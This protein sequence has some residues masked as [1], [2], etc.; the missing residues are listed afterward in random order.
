MI[1]P[2]YLAFKSLRWDGR[3]LVS[4]FF[5]WKWSHDGE[6]FYTIADGDPSQYDDCGIFAGS[7]PEAL[8][9]SEPNATSLF[10]ISP[11]SNHSSDLVILHE[12][13]WRSLSA[14]VVGIIKEFDFAGFGRD[15]PEVPQYSI[16]EAFG[17]IK[18][19]QSCG[20]PQLFGN[21]YLSKLLRDLS[22]QPK[23][24][25][26]VIVKKYGVE[27]LMKISPSV[28]TAVLRYVSRDP[29]QV[30]E[31]INIA[32]SENYPVFDLIES[33]ERTEAL[34]KVCL[35]AVYCFDEEQYWYW[36]LYFSSYNPESSDLA[37][38]FYKNFESAKL[39]A[40]KYCKPILKRRHEWLR[41][42]AI[43]FTRRWKP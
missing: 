16:E 5:K 9:Y 15:R 22:A 13:G 20:Y 41:D 29:K 12:E 6:Y 36:T 18:Q 43:N 25:T 39:E 1:S 27:F 31:L 34:E 40:K 14:T 8:R 42:K 33:V 37:L 28:M 17:L 19:L 10:L 23:Y 21:T 3:T 26:D 2:A 4:P 7:L 38:S 35:Q 24:I 32:V 11:S 30:E